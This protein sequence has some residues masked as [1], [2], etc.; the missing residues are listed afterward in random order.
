M[1]Y[2]A[3]Q[4][5]SPSGKPAGRSQG[6]KLYQFP[7]RAIS[8]PTDVRMDDPNEEFAQPSM[9]VEIAA[10]MLA[11]VFWLGWRAMHLVP[12]SR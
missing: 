2:R 11:L 8:Y 9:V 1:I 10:G 3:V 6:A 12:A 4:D 5:A 7:Y